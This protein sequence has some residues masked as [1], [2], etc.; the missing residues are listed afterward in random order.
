MKKEKVD[1]ILKGGVIYTVNNNF[2]IVEALAVKDGKVRCAGTNED[3]EAGYEATKIIDLKGKSAYPG[4]IDAHCHFY[5]YGTDRLLYADLT[6]TR[7]FDEVIKVL[8]E[9]SGLHSENNWL[10]GRG[11]DQND[12]EN[13]RFPDNSELNKLFPDK[14]VVLIRIDGHAVLANK[15]ALEIAGIHS[16]T[17]IPGGKLLKTKGKLTGVLLDNAADKLKSFIPPLSGQQIFKALL[18]AQDDCFSVGLTSVVDAG[19]DKNVVDN[20]DSLNKN[21]KLK[22]RIYAMLSPTVENIESYVKKGIYK[23]PYLHISSIKLYADGALGSRGACLLKPYSDDPG[24]YGFLVNTPE[25]LDS[26]CSVA[27][28]NGFQVNTHAIGDSAVRTV[29]NI[30][31]GYLKNGN[32][33][34]WRIEH[35]QVVTYEDFGLY[36]KLNVIPAVNTTHA[37]SDMYWAEKRLGKDRIKNAYAYKKLLKQNGWLTNG[38]DFPVESINPVYGFYAAVARKDLNGYP[39]GGFQPENALT[40]K[41]ALKAMTIW[42]AKGSFEENEKGSLE[43]GKYADIVITDRD[44]MKCDIKEVPYTKV[45]YTFSGGEMVFENES[46][47][48][49]GRREK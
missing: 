49:E 42:A 12:W 16:G 13:K 15:K 36:G 35:S 19:L 3:I 5:G 24:N 32:D 40:R 27:A 30:Y 26:L 25:Y 43:A 4:F 23:T 34:R 33:K 45:V 29:L 48:R 21:G 8:K 17:V 1:L 9:F 39:E 6:G 18:M 47:S 22:M 44:I 37:T 10:L 46:L 11:W 7:S 38:S 2:D 28:E 41:E 31:S 20:I 14:P